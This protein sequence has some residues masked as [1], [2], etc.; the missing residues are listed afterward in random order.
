MELISWKRAGG[1][2][3]GRT[4]ERVSPR[5]LRRGAGGRLALTLLDVFRSGTSFSALI[6]ASSSSQARP[7]F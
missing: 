3:W 2:T 7:V 1:G 6:L 4:A 5:A